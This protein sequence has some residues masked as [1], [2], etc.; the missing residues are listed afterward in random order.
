MDTASS[1]VVL[2]S[3][4][5]VAKSVLMTEHQKN[6]FCETFR[7]FPEVVLLKKSS[8]VTTSTTV[9]C[10]GKKGSV[11]HKIA[12]F[13]RHSYVLNMSFVWFKNL[14]SDQYDKQK[15]WRTEDVNFELLKLFID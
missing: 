7:A 4:G 15:G 3:F 11:R 6:A 13:Y 10:K 9:C 1:G 8:Q 14:M 12:L 2:I 5:S